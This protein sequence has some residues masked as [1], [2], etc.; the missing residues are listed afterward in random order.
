VHNQRSKIGSRHRDASQTQKLG[1][2]GFKFCLRSSV[3]TN[4]AKNISRCGKRKR[5]S[6]EERFQQLKEFQE[7]HD[8]CDVPL[9][10]PGGLGV[11][12]NDQRTKQKCQRLDAGQA[13]KLEE[14]GFRWSMAGTKSDQW[15]A[16][17]R[18]L[19][20]F[21]EEHG[22]C[23]VPR[24]H[25]G[26]LGFW[27]E[28][29]RRGGKERS[30]RRDAEQAQKLEVL[31]FRWDSVKR[32]PWQTRFRQLKEFKEEHGHCDVPLKH[33][34]GLGSWVHNQ[35]SKIGSRH[36]DASQTQKL[37]ELGFKFCLRSSVGTNPAKNISRCGEG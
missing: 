19:K 5:C 4:P 26:G 11:W 18:K 23:D 12:A 6:P 36:R 22:H 28:Y 17:F 20:E 32:L 7:E 1:E 15:E 37:G 21:K 29:Q 9:K 24:T 35:R 13:R 16:Q 30:R 33:P 25:P 3:G 2:L 34:G 10:Y 27:V 31:G 14:L 8:H